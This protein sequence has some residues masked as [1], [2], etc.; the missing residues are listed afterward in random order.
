LYRCQQADD[1]CPDHVLPLYERSPAARHG[2]A[3][4]Q[5]LLAM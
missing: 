5:T 4:P 1:V 2:N 3:W